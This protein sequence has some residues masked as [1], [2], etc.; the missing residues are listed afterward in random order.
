MSDDTL[1]SSTFG[2]QFRAL[3]QKANISI[4]NLAVDAMIEPKGLSN[5][6][7]GGTRRCRESTLKKLLAALDRALK[8][9][10]FEKSQRDAD[11]AALRATWAQ[12]GLSIKEDPWP[13]GNYLG[14][15]PE[16]PMVAREAELKKLVDSLDYVIARGKARCLVLTGEP[17]I[18]KTR[19]TQEISLIARDRGMAV[20]VGTC[21]ELKCDVPLYPFREALS[22]ASEAATEALQ[23]AVSTHLLD[24]ASLLAYRDIRMEG[25]LPS[26]ST[27]DRQA[28]LFYQV[29]RF[30]QALANERPIALLIDDLHWADATSC[31]LFQ[32]VASLVHDR[33]VLLIGAYRKGRATRGQA[34]AAMMNVLRGKGLVQRI[35]LTPI[36][37]EGTRTVIANYLNLEQVSDEFAQLLH[38]RSEGNPFVT[39]ELVSALIAQQQLYREKNGRW[40]RRAI[41]ELKLPDTIAAA[42]QQRFMRL[43]LSAQKV[44]QDASAFGRYF[45]LEDLQGLGKRARKTLE[46]A[47]DEA[48][49]AELIEEGLEPAASWRVATTPES[50][51]QNGVSD[52]SDASLALDERSYYY[53]NHAYTQEALYDMLEPLRKQ[54]LHKEIGELLAGLPEEA[55]RRAGEIAHHF[56]NA[57]Q[58][59][60]ALPYLVEAGD[61]AEGMYAHAGAKLQYEHALELARKL[62]NVP[63]EARIL[64]HLGSVLYHTGRYDDAIQ[65]LEAAVERYQ[66]LGESEGLASAAAGLGEAYARGGRNAEEGMQ[67]VRVLRRA[68]R[69]G[70]RLRAP[71]TASVA[72][73]AHGTRVVRV[74]RS[75]VGKKDTVVLQGNDDATPNI[76]QQGLT[77]RVE[78]CLSISLAHLYWCL[79][80]YSEQL[81][82]AEEATEYARAANDQALEAEGHFWRGAAYFSMRQMEAAAAAADLSVKLA[83]RTANA[84]TL[85]GALSILVTLADLTGALDQASDYGQQGLDAAERMGDPG[86]ILI[87]LCNAAGVSFSKGDWSSTAVML[88]RME[89]VA[90]SC[91]SESVSAFLPLMR[92]SLLLAQGRCKEGSEQLALASEHSQRTDV[93][94]AAETALAEYEIIDGRASDALVRLDALRHRI[95]EEH[96]WMEEVLP[97]LSWAH[98]QMG[99]VGEAERA[100]QEAYAKATASSNHTALLHAHI[101]HALLAR[102][103]EKWDDA[104]DYIH[105]ALDLARSMPRQWDEIKA[106]F[107]AGKVLKAQGDTMHAQQEFEQ[108][109]ALCDELGEGLFRPHIV[110]MLEAVSP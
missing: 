67:R 51:K 48:W 78:A 95:G 10:G 18:G 98:L 2:V 8:K 86:E 4:H 54:R 99:E 72:S 74:S 1:P 77:P 76:A 89:E 58:R 9:E 63:M 79:D 32:H 15:R 45:T 49:G 107:A 40:E 52:V 42:I 36:S 93:Q 59:E 22:K 19:L 91:G 6:E 81:K 103:H 13:E 7:L 31:D 71:V 53:F 43:S 94:S 29:V 68:A 56:L 47:L 38:D 55:Q 37:A 24:L 46:N 97:L 11:I 30:L 64:D 73:I 100:L 39:R 70:A 84:G 27:S 20:A 26:S 17:G 65:T 80:R 69:S 50:S 60:R 82:A 44:L 90:R 21:D 102:E 108:A 23:K 105:A 66:S 87:A 85:Q 88:E 25:K 83:K 34:L 41:K 96:P 3:R 104:N 35:P 75:D 12:P 14:T 106:H 61:Q 110:E 57:H 101:A 62:K 33:P 92:G 28:V 109:L 5:L 16:D